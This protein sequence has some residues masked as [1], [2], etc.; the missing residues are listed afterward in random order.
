M[1]FR[2]AIKDRT[3]GKVIIA[4]LKDPRMPG[5]LGWQKYSITGDE[6]DI[7]YVGHRFLPTRFDY[8]LK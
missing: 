7:H 1:K 6:V 3:K 5:W 4:S 8:K 2:Y